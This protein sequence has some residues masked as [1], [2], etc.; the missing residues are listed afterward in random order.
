[1]NRELT[2]KLARV[3]EMMKKEGYDSIL[4][5]ENGAVAVFDSNQ[6]KSV[7]NQGTFSRE[8]NNIYKQAYGERAKA[9]EKLKRDIAAWK[10]FIEVLPR[11]VWHKNSKQYK[12]LIHVIQLIFL[13]ILSGIHLIY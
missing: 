11:K 1:M 4:D 7:D 5:E 6:I 2:T 10:A 3:R 8:D 13:K 9:R 12:K